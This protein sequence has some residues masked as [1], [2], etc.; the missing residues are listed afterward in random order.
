M[1]KDFD[2]YFLNEE[3]RPD[4]YVNELLDKIQFL[5]SQNS[6]LVDRID[7]L[8]DDIRELEKSNDDQSGK[9]Y[10][11]EESFEKLEKENSRLEDEIERL[12]K[13]EEEWID[14]KEDL[15][16]EL[17]IYT[18]PYKIFDSGDEQGKIQVVDSFLGVLDLMEDR[19]IEFGSTL[20][21]EIKST[22]FESLVS[23]MLNK[24]WVDTYTGSAASLLN[25]FG[26]KPN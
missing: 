11:L 8:E 1:I 4:K 24:E 23:A 3:E 14:E 6:D 12:E 5:E 9:I 7:E 25:R 17:V 10:G 20:R 21:K 26:K 16:R 22:R 18:D 15:V 19:P 2:N 13:L